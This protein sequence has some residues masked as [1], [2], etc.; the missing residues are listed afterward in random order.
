MKKI[1]TTEAWF[2]CT[3]YIQQKHESCFCCI[4]FFY[5]H[6]TQQ[7]HNFIDKYITKLCFVFFF[8][9]NPLYNRIILPLCNFFFIPTNGNM[10]P[11][12][13]VERIFLEIEN[14]GGTNSNEVEANNNSPFG[15]GCEPWISTIYCW[16]LLLMPIVSNCCV[17]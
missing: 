4:Y 10:I 7:K 14:I 13:N 6:W 3:K 2:H 11:Q 1:D 12:Y 5:P 17:L 8:F 15:M 9:C 16:L